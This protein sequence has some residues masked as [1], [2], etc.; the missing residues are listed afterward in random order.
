[1]N[2][3]SSSVGE[4]MFML[5][6]FCMM[7]KN[8]FDHL[9]NILV[10]VTLNDQF[11]SFGNNLDIWR[12]DGRPGNLF[13]RFKKISYLNYNQHF[14]SPPLSIFGRSYIG[15]FIKGKFYKGKF[16]KGKFYKGKFYKGKFNNCMLFFAVKC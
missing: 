9:D 7:D 15:K 1:M 16:I 2:V 12:S 5:S 10:N 6:L 13:G 4:S 14:R 3:W 11:S 8:I